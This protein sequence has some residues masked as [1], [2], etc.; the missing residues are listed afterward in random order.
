MSSRRVSISVHRRVKLPAGLAGGPL[1]PRGRS[2]SAAEVGDTDPGCYQVW[3]A[4]DV[5]HAVYAER[6][7]ESDK[8]TLCTNRLTDRSFSAVFSVVLDYY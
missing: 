6:N 3:V 1:R 4:G 5:D 8:D 2:G 7:G